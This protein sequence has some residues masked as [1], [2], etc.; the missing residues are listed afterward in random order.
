MIP[1]P[2]TPSS[3]E[4]AVLADQFRLLV[5]EDQVVEI[6]ALNVRKGNYKPYTVSGFFDGKHRYEMAKAALSVTPMATGTYFSLNPL[7]P[8]LLARRFNRIDRADEADCAK[9][10]DVLFRRQ[11]PLDFDPVRPAKISATDAEKQK[12]HVIAIKVRDYLRGRGWPDPSFGDSGNG[13]H[14]L[15][16]IN[17]PADDG[18]IVKDI[19]WLLARLFDTAEV[20]IDQAVHN[21]SRIWKLPGTLARKGDDIPERPHRRSV[22][23]EKPNSIQEVPRALLEEMAS[24]SRKMQDEEKRKAEAEKSQNQSTSNKGNYPF[25]LVEDWLR[26]RSVGFRVK[27]DKDDKARTVYVLDICPFDKSHGKDSCVM[28]ETSG[29]MSAKCLHSSCSGRGWAKFRDA[30]GKPEGRHYR[31]PS[32]HIG[33]G[34]SDKG[35]KSQPTNNGY[36]NV[37]HGDNCRDSRDGVRENSETGWGPP[38]ALPEMPPAAD[39]P[40]GL[41]P[42]VIADYWQAHAE[43]LHVPVDYVAVPALPLLG[44]A[45]GRSRAAA[46][47]RTYAEPPL[48]WC[49]LVAPPGR[50]KSPALQA[51]KGPLSS[52]TRKWR[53]QYREKL[54]SYEAACAAYESKFKEWKRNPDDNPPR[55]PDKPVLTQL[56]IDKF[57]VESL[58]RINGD[59]PR[60][61]A[62]AQDELSGLVTGLGQ[63]KGGKGDDKQTMLSLWAGAEAEVNRV[64]DKESGGMPLY[65]PHSFVGIA[66]MI[67]PDLLPLLRGDFG[68]ANFINDGWADRFLLS[69]PTPPVL[70]GESWATVSEELERGYAGVFENLLAMEMVAEAEALGAIHHRPY[71]LTFTRQAKNAWQEF[72]N[73]IAEQSNKLDQFDNY[74][75]VLS[76]LKHYGLRLTTL[77]HCLRVACGELAGTN[78]IDGES[79]RRAEV[80]VSYFE[81]HGRRC[82]G[83][84][85]AD[86]PSRIAH[87]LLAWLARTPD[88]KMFNRTDAFIV[89]KDKRDVKTSEVLAPAF[90]I[91]IDH[92]YIRPLALPE[93]LRPGPIPESYV[94]NPAWVRSSPEP[95]PRIPTVREETEKQSSNCRDSRDAVQE[96]QATSGEDDVEE[97]A[98]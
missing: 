27:P 60:G 14:E 70:T 82:L 52:H 45:V 20:K 94:V 18:G 72:T 32:C 29:K 55:K 56:V 66:G 43:S 39:F 47:K 51:A 95:I 67:Q 84:G 59:N 26:D 36:Q 88:R 12:A 33:N 97:F 64:K 83:L 53:D 1:G 13:Y 98:A 89:L 96:D 23:L 41:F 19:L 62:L 9:D 65:I 76:K 71:Y 63:Y 87:R 6:R 17:L 91:L 11:L 48:L 68:R 38:A 34:L 92:D 3:D 31:Q 30:I 24:E 40:L 69:F 10:K 77:L 16:K 93:N 21:P 7:N 49:V 15:Y 86:R 46:V 25:L 54:K 90:R 50:A 22:I 2:V 8:A 79:V 35:G 80:L 81:S 58:V 73:F 28:Q 37:Q 44:A 4:A 85:W 57:T 74:I 42:P 61:L 75:G 5:V 78:E